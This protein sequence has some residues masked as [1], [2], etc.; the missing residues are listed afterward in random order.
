MKH[1]IHL[2]FRTIFNLAVLFVCTCFLA[3]FL[4][5]I[6]N[7]DSRHQQEQ[8]SRNSLEA[9]ASTIDSNAA[10]IDSLTLI[11][12][13]IN[14]STLDD[15]RELLMKDIMETL[16]N[17]SHSDRI[18]LFQ[19]IMN[20]AGVDYLYLL[21]DAG[22]VI[23][24]PVADYY[25]ENLTERGI[26]TSDNFAALKAG[27][28]TG[29][30]IDPIYEK[31]E[32][33]AVYY[34]STPI[35]FAGKT[36]Y[37]ILGASGDILDEHFSYLND[38]IRVADNYNE[39]SDSF[40][41]VISNSTEILSYYNYGNDNYTGEFISSLGISSEISDDSYSGIQ[42]IGGKQ[43]FCVSKKIHGYTLVNATDLDVLYGRSAGFLRW[44]VMVFVIIAL[45]CMAYAVILLNSSREDKVYETGKK[46]FSL[47][48]LTI[49]FNSILALKLVPII[50]LFAV[51]IFFTS[52]YSQ[53]LFAIANAIYSSESSLEAVEPRITETIDTNKAI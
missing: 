33:G 49:Y 24:A 4:T 6:Q 37:L 52:F 23:M 48:R 51:L 38:I 29:D 9:A 44:S 15:L 13:Q 46:Q 32:N 42:T 11:F 36:Y 30:S 31:S 40:M 28:D 17:G 2:L 45:L 5:T 35:I 19:S 39:N 1:H 12:H 3:F 27:T 34:Y 10:N 14:Q 22:K 50:L 7:T 53:S 18:D 25:G 43:F 20:K 8:I 21:D 16:L 47:G 41:F 26:L